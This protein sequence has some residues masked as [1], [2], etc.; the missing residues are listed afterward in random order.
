MND[1]QLL[2]DDFFLD[3]LFDK[4]GKSVGMTLS[5]TNSAPVVLSFVANRLMRKSAKDFQKKFGLGAMDFRML[6]MLIKHPGSSVG[7]AS[8]VIGIDKAAVSRSLARLH[9]TGLA[10]AKNKLKDERRKSWYLSQAGKELHNRV[11][12]DAV[13]GNRILLTGF[14]EAEAKLLNQFLNRLLT[15]VELI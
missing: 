5:F 12:V 10:I 13:K 7:D 8:T 3:E 1:L 15:N 11:L 6:V 2:S 4:D 14:S 9:K